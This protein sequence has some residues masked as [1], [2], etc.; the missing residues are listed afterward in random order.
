MERLTFNE[1]KKRHPDEWVLLADPE[2][3]NALTHLSG[4]LIAHSPNRT[5]IY[6]KQR[7]LVGDYAILFTGNIS[8]DKIF[9]L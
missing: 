3:A 8:K 6:K 5:D 2:E 1:I 7:N 4:I 9:V